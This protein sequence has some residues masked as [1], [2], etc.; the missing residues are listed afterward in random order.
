MRGKNPVLATYITE[1][2]CCMNHYLTTS[3]KDY[4][5]FAKLLAY[6][7]HRRAVFTKQNLIPLL[8]MELQSTIFRNYFMTQNN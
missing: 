6:I 2:T 8:L 7:N 1:Q 5:S 4:S 3:G